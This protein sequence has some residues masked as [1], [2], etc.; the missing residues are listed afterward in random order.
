MNPDTM[1]SRESAAGK[2]LVDQLARRFDESYRLLAYYAAMPLILT[3]D[4]L[5]F[6]SNRFLRGKA[7][8]VAEVDL[9]LSDIC[10]QVGHEQFMMDASARAYLLSDM[11]KVIGAHKLQ[12]AARLLISYVRHLY[13]SQ[14]YFSEQELQAQQWGAMAFIGDQRESVVREIAASVRNNMDIIASQQKPGGDVN[15]RHE[16]VRLSGVLAMM[17]PQLNE[18]PEL[19]NYSSIISKLL[20]SPNTQL[21]EELS[22]EDLDRPVQVL[23]I[24]LPAPKIVFQNLVVE[25]GR[26]NLASPA[27][28]AEAESREEKKDPFINLVGKSKAFKEVL[29][30]AER[31]ARS[32][33]TALVKGESGTGKTSLARAIHEGSSRSR[34]PFVVLNLSEF[35]PA[36]LEAELIGYKR[37]AFTGATKTKQG[38]LKTAEGGTILLNG[39]DAVDMHTQWRLVRILQEKQITPFGA[40]K[41][42]RTNV[43]VLAGTTEDLGEAVREGRFI[44]DL[45]ACFKDVLEIPPLRERA[46]D[47]PLLAS[48]LVAKADKTRSI[49]LAASFVKALQGYEWPGNLLE[50]EELINDLVNQTASNNLTVKLLPDYILNS[51]K[52]D[53]RPEGLARFGYAGKILIRRSTDRVAL[54][55][56]EGEHLIFKLKAYGSSPAFYFSPGSEYWKIWSDKDFPAQSNHEYEREWPSNT[57]EVMA[58]ADYQFFISFA[59]ATKYTL[60][61]EHHDRDHNVIEI[62]KDVDYE[63]T[64]KRDTYQEKLK[65]SLEKELSSYKAAAADSI[66]P[67]KYGTNVL[68]QESFNSLLSFLDPD[69]EVAGNKYQLIYRKLLRYFERYEIASPDALAD[70][71]IN[72][73][74]IRADQIKDTYE[75]DPTRYFFGVANRVHSQ[76]RKR[77]RLITMPIVGTESHVESEDEEFVCLERCLQELSAENRDLVLSYYQEEKA[78]RLASRKKL[79]EELGINATALRVRVHRIKLT[80]QSCILECLKRMN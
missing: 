21:K 24:T 47:I 53:S 22:Q 30:K 55:L 59:A 57:L 75:G 76:Y 32:D 15:S 56:A 36:L 62:I 72:R 66:S 54:N 70:E 37:G 26:A 67:E 45:Y 69:P 14:S 8:W 49:K 28:K 73:V 78:I 74:A 50:L 40:T 4:L 27:S 10:N 34:G 71:V 5:H 18:F 48:Y 80:L 29:I 77:R 79:A 12:E 61:I 6:L 58:D 39:I 20:T 64:S 35:E 41:P 1:T 68:T 11:A 3:P 38:A 23:D 63:S 7:P 60:R 44:N 42:T 19:L 31:L 46:E 16:L 43:R 25:N 33:E 65:I 52:A 2:V 17:R 9:L 13:R 51:I